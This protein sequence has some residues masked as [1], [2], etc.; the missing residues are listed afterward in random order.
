MHEALFWAELPEKKVQCRLCRFRCMIPPGGRGR[1][2]VRENRDGKLYSLVYGRAIAEAVD[3]IEK[4]PLYHFLPGSRSYSIATVGC[5]FSCLHCQNA[6]ISQPTPEMVSCGGFALPPRVAVERAVAEGCAS[7][8]YTY[9]EP[10]IF[11]EYAWDMAR[12]ARDRGIRNVFVTN[13]YT[14]EEALTAIA[15]LLDA[16]NVDLKFFSEKSYREVTGGSLQEVLDSLRVYKR[17][18]IWVE[19]TTLIIPGFNDG[20]EELR[21]IAGFVASELGV[22]TPW[23]VTAFHPTYKMLDVP[24]TP[25]ST[26]RRARE[27]GIG[28]GLLHVYEGNLASGEGESTFC[29]SCRKK[30]I[31]RRGFSLCASHMADGKCGFCGEALAGVWK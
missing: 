4:K 19:I 18:G 15:P 25:P 31:D 9:T 23:H 29:P 10:T 14:S 28:E 21:Q 26:L 13:G 1:C 5:N 30:V 20:E 2:R 22:G 8:A 12:L 6:D 17:L 11:F 3:P 16:A 24:R 7:I 27:I